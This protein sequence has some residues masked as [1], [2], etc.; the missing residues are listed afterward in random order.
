M[1]ESGNEFARGQIAAG[2][3]DDDGAWLDRSA[4]NVKA[5]TENF[6]QL[7]CCFHRRII[8]RKRQKVTAAFRARQTQGRTSFFLGF[9][10]LGGIPVIEPLKIDH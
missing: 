8:R 9:S 7:I 1:E 6:I 3:E 2:S 5:A 10:A 4:A